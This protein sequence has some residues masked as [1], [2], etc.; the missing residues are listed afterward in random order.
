MPFT[1]A[2]AFAASHPNHAP[3][4]P[5]D[6][7]VHP[8]P[9]PYY[10]SLAAQQPFGFDASLGMWVAAGPEALAEVLRHPACGVRPAGGAV[11]PAL[12]AG[13][14]GEWFGALVRMNDGPAHGAMKPWLAARLAALHADRAALV[15][16]HDATQAACADAYLGRGKAPGACLDDFVFR[17]PVYALAAWLGVPAAQWADVH[18][19]VRRLVAAM[20]ASGKPSPDTDVLSLGHTAATALRRRATRWLDSEGIPGT[21]LRETARRAARDDA[22]DFGM[23]RANVV[24]LFTQTHDACAGLVANSVRRLARI[25]ATGETPGASINAPGHDATGAVSATTAD[26]IRTVGDVIRVDPPIQ[27]TRRFLHAP[28]VIG[29]HTLAKGDT[30]LVVLASAPSGTSPDGVAWTF[31]IGTHACPGRSPAS[32]IA[33]LGVQ[34][35]LDSAVDLAPLASGTTY[36]PLANARIARFSA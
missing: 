19:D 36:H 27:N 5:I 6:A 2:D 4:N 17:Q 20:A 10:A 1:N 28:A 15:R 3:A 18:D 7:V 13:P 30:I 31:G 33:A 8:D 9:Y 25:A 23:V 35:I 12:A 32:T 16:L 14:A 29:G 34:A 22:I 24:G 11:P 21:W 26:A